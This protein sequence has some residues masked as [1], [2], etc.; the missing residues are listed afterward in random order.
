ML[1]ALAFSALGV[2]PVRADGI[3]Y[4]KPVA[5]GSGDCSSW[6]NACT[7]QTALTVSLSGN[8]I[9]VAAGTYKPT[10]G[11][12]RTATFHLKNGVAVYGGFAGT[13]TIR[14]QRNPATNITILSGD[15]DNNDSQTPIITDLS[16][17]TGNATN[18][19]HVVAGASSATLDGFTITAGN[20]NESV[21]PNN[22]GAGMY[23]YS[24]NSLALTNLTF[25]GNSAGYG[26][27][28]LNALSSPTVTSATFYGNAATSS[29][30]GMLNYSSSPTLLNTDL[31]DNSAGWGGGMYNESG[32]I[33]TLTNV[34]FGSNS[35][36]YGG[37]MENNGSNPMLASVTFD[38]NAAT[39]SG[40]GM[41]NY[42]SSPTLMNI[43]FSNNSAG[44]GGGMYNEAN[45]SPSLT[46]IAF[47]GNTASYSGGGMLNNFSS[48]TL[49]AITFSNNWANYGGGIY[50][51]GNSV[52]AVANNTLSGNHAT[53][54]GGGIYNYGTV[55]VT[56]STLSGNSTNSPESSGGGIYN[57]G[58]LTLIGSTLSGNSADAFIGNSTYGGGI[59][60]DSGAVTVTNSTLSGN[61]AT[62]HGVPFPGV[63]PTYGYGGGIFSDGGSLTLTNS[64]FSG[65]YAVT[66]GGGVDILNGGV[67]NFTN[68][69]I[70][71]SYSGDCHVA[72]TIA[73]NTNNLVEDGSCAAG[74]VNFK[75]GDPLL[76]ALADNGGPTWTMALGMGSPAI[77]AGNNA[78][79]PAADQRGVSRPQDGDNDSIAICDIGAYEVGTYTLTIT[80]AHGTVVR[81]PSQAGYYEG[82]VVQLTATPNDGW[83]FV[84]WTGDLT[85]T[86]NPASVT[87]HGNTSVTANY[88]L[89][90]QAPTNI[91]LSN[92]SV[93]E[94]LSIGAT[95]GTLTTTDPDPGDTHT[96]SFCG[97][98]NDNFFAIVGDALNTAAVFDFETKSSYNICI[99][100][101]DGNGG[102]FDKAF[103][104]T[105]TDVDDNSVFKIFLPLTLR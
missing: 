37:G 94:N 82:N 35:A 31:V 72:G 2:T 81:D 32:S 71:N 46:N 18:S 44:W 10:T 40:G 55:T 56:N 67:L 47:S 17:V 90:N 59:Y 41:L 3:I 104:I 30:G 87:I 45:S 54:R 42:S 19:Y 26:G 99:R 49:T 63:P 21:S 83:I 33:P 22:S 60:N 84:N 28:M 74:G 6:G 7:L 58:T 75:S 27:G 48:P 80:S 9:W 25:S 16:T 85:S 11:T 96:Y 98:A 57:L 78:V 77:D 52:L 65:N 103:A 79:C 14:D 43:T 8:E 93:L 62:F 1:L 88:M 51:D 89:D 5:A 24:C 68:T 20:A 23:N 100:T 50:N 91:I 34:T 38:G 66:T 95:V 69:I 61:F 36:T 97:G 4:A 86:A 39:S 13:E 53:S 105:I 101:D 73:T 102:A 64:T 12:G 92:D 29:G 76:S 70:A 15:I